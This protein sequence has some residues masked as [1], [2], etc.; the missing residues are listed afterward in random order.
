MF[1]FISTYQNHFTKECDSTGCYDIYYSTPNRK[2][3]KIFYENVT[4]KNYFKNE[5]QVLSCNLSDHFSILNKLEMI[6]RPSKS[7]SF[8]LNY[9]ENK[10]NQ[11][12][13][14]IRSPLILF[15]NSLNPFPK[16]ETGLYAEQGNKAFQKFYGL[17]KT[18]RYKQNTYIAGANT[19]DLWFY[20]LGNFN[21][22]DEVK[23]PAYYENQTRVWEVELWMEIKFN[24]AIMKKQSTRSI[25]PYKS[26]RS[27]IMRHH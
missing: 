9:P 5:S 23:I 16:N 15:N 18:D 27:R 24:K 2:W 17:Y 7:Y 20:A 3:I 12:F 25:N 1:F 22:D 4:G 11:T 8:I 6:N 10:V 19:T 13:S 14:Q 21:R 26:I